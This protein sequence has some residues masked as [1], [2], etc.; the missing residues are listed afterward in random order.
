MINFLKLLNFEWNR[1]IKLYSILF[2]LVFVV[3]LIGLLLLITGY[4]SNI[5]LEVTQ[6]NMSHEA[7]IATYGTFGLDYIGFSLLFI[8]PIAIS[9]AALLFYVPFIW[10][11][12]WF[13]RNTFIYRLLMLP[14]SR[15]N[16]FMAKLTT[17]MIGILTMV[18]YQILL[19]LL[20]KEIIKWMIPSAFR[21]DM[22]VL[23]YVMDSAYLSIFLPSGLMEFFISY[24]LGLSA[25]I[26]TF[27]VILLER[28]FRW[29]G[30]L[31]GV[32][33]MPATFVIFLSPI[34]LTEIFPNTLSLYPSE[35]FFIQSGLWLIIT[36]GSLWF[37]SYLLKRRVT[38]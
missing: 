3:Q 18:A 12:D 27:T 16:L 7:F 17:I 28:S 4:I 31:I 15:M 35:L 11:R 23:D 13:A 24:G 22:G 20:Y 8:A 6:N 14:T 25:V 36:A 33:Y 38:V 21:N 5:R 1:F 29:I 34:I 2:V 37:S 32:F 9:V 10:Y 19:L 30:V 26:V